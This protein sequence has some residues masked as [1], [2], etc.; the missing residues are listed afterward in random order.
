MTSLTFSTLLLLKD[1]YYF[2]L[3][4]PEVFI[5]QLFDKRRNGEEMIHLANKIKETSSL[6][7]SKT[8]RYYFIVGIEKKSFWG[9]EKIILFFWVE[10]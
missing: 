8:K 9:L 10:C 5:L 3:I 2:E 4:S 6:R 7:F 1:H